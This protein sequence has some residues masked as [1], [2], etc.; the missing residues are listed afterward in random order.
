M[1][2]L[3]IL[4]PFCEKVPP[5]NFKIKPK[6]LNEY[7]QPISSSETNSGGGRRKK[8]TRKK[9]GRGKCASKPKY[10]DEEEEERLRELIEKSSEHMKGQEEKLK[11]MMRV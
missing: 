11:K 7:L 2:F 10:N 9:R 6:G 1:I 8:K 3:D 4:F 5:L